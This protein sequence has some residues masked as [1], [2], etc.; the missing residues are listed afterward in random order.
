MKTPFDR[1]LLAFLLALAFMSAT[2][3]CDWPW[4]QPTGPTTIQ[5]QTVIIGSQPSPSPSAS[6]ST[7]PAGF[8]ATPSQPVAALRFGIRSGSCSVPASKGC[9]VVSIRVG[10]SVGLDIS[11]LDAS[12]QLVACHGYI[13]LVTV[14]TAGP[15]DLRWSG[16]ADFLPT[17]I[18]ASI[19]ACQL[20]G[21]VNGTHGSLTV[22]V[23]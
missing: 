21:E 16:G 5:Q 14:P 15:C 18:G 17:V 20:Q 2:V 1:G 10:E 3:A 7:A 12:G 8:C 19:G 6:P 4:S 9:S 23:K 13:S 11:P 22:D